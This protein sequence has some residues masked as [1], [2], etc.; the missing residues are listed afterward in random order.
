[1]WLEIIYPSILLKSVS[2]RSTV[3]S[4]KK[5]QTYVSDTGNPYHEACLGVGDSFVISNVRR[6]IVCEQ[7]I[8]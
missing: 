5:P 2:K 4:L 8:N 7:D 6:G 1:M 3:V